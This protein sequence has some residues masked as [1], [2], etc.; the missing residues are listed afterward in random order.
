[1]NVDATE[2]TAIRGVHRRFS[3]PSLDAWSPFAILLVAHWA[4]ANVQTRRDRKQAAA[5]INRLS[6]QPRQPGISC[7]LWICPDPQRCG[8][9]HDLRREPTTSGANTGRYSTRPSPSERR[10]PWI[11]RAIQ[12]SPSRLAKVEV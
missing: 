5:A 12:A 2:L 6:R 7:K 1:M 8:T 10:R 9:A 4:T 3:G 11:A